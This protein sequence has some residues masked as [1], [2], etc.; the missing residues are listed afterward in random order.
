MSL[1]RAGL[2]MRIWPGVQ[3]SD[4]SH[5][6][7][8]LVI[9]PPGCIMLLPLSVPASDCI[10]FSPSAQRRLEIYVQL[11]PG[12][13][14]RLLPIQEGRYSYL[15]EKENGD[16]GFRSSVIDESMFELDRFVKLFDL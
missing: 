5:A 7:D 13:E 12:R 11:S 10:G 15:H 6:N 9:I 1:D 14:H 3:S 8:R 16:D 4:G 2:A